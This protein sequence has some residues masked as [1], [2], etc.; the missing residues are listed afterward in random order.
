VIEIRKQLLSLASEVSGLIKD[1]LKGRKINIAPFVVK[2]EGVIINYP[3]PHG[4][5]CSVGSYPCSQCPSFLFYEN[6]E[7]EGDATVLNVYC[8]YGFE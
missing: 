2:T 4:E 3:C 7:R 6:K 8:W 1:R 5:K